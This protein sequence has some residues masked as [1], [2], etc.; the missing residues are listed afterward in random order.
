MIGQPLTCDLLRGSLAGFAGHVVWADVGTAAEDAEHPLHRFHRAVG[1]PWRAA[2]SL[3]A[4]HYFNALLI[5]GAALLATSFPPQAKVAAITPAFCSTTGS[6]LGFALHAQPSSAGFVHDLSRLLKADLVARIDIIHRAAGL[7]RR[8]L[9]E[10]AAL[11]WAW[12]VQEIAVLDPAA[13]RRLSRRAVLLDLPMMP[14]FKT[15]IAGPPSKRRFCCLRWTV[16]GCR[17][18][19]DICPIQARAES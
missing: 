19:P 16:P 14:A 1:G 10:S 2:C 18:C 7:S 13:S 3:W 9:E 4:Q 8:M 5:P 15:V 11:S 17:A 6:P 12:A